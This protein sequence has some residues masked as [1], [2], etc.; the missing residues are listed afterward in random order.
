MRVRTFNPFIDC[1]GTALIFKQEQKVVART[2]VF[3]FYDCSQG[4][5]EMS[6]LK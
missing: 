3:K 4:F 5:Y 6:K 1:S 2:L